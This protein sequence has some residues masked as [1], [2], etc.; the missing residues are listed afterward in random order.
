[1]IEPITYDEVMSELEKYARVRGGQ[2][3]YQFTPQMD[4]LLTEGRKKKLS[5]DAI[6]S[7]WKKL[8]WGNIANSTLRARAHLLEGKES[9]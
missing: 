3:A 5:F 6:R 1:M 4:A 8:G 2:N 9:Q 7:L